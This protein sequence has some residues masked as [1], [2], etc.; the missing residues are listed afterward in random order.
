LSCTEQLLLP[1]I[2][3]VID[4]EFPPTKPPVMD[5]AEPKHV[6][7]QTDKPPLTSHDMAIETEQAASRLDLIETGPSKTESPFTETVVSTHKLEFTV[8]GLVTDTGPSMSTCEPIAVERRMERLPPTEDEP[9]TDKSAPIFANP[10]IDAEE[11]EYVPS[12][13]DILPA[14]CR[15]SPTDKLSS[16][17]HLPVMLRDPLRSMSLSIRTIELSNNTPKT[18][19]APPTDR[20]PPMHASPSRYV[21]LNASIFEA[22]R[23]I[24]PTDRLEP[25]DAL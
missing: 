19:V 8:I 25:K 20:E 10:L 21:S 16:T 3:S 23:A 5:A 17:R 13:T 24:P 4:N 11:S 15:V 9:V 12:F 22:S 18:E 14:T 7:P 2:S 1:K 6:K